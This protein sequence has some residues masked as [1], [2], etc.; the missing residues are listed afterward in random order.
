LTTTAQAKN[1]S[2][3]LTKAAKLKSKAAFFMP[4]KTSGLQASIALLSF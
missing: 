2:I 4:V 1:I 3:K